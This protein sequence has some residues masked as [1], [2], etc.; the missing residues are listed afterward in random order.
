MAESTLLV[1]GLGNVLCGD[2]GLGVAAIREISSRYR[3]PPEVR[4]LDGGTMGLAL[5][6]LFDRSQDAILVDAVEVDERPGSI[7]RIDGEQVAPAVR[8]RLSVHQVG[9]ADLLDGLHLI[10]EYPRRLVLLG[11][12]P[13]STDLTVE[14]S[15]RVEAGLPGL[16]TAVVDEAARMGYRLMPR[17]AHEI[18]SSRHQ[19]FS[20]GAVGV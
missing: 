20:R 10:G 17:A 2:D 4:V 1:L 15:A 14:L 11:L 12:V 13:E 9:V 8:S 19:Y 7:V 6:S 5:L 18:E 3:M 16:V